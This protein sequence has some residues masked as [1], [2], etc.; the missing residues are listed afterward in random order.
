M[1]TLLFAALLAAACNLPRP[2]RVTTDGGADAMVVA[3]ASPNMVVGHSVVTHILYD[4]SAVMTNEDLSGYKVQAYLPNAGKAS[5]YDI[6]DGSGD[7]NGV[8]TID[9]VPAGATYALVLTPPVSLDNPTP[10][11]TFYFTDHHDLDLGY[12]VL[13][14]PQSKAVANNTPVS[15]TLSNMTTWAHPF[16]EIWVDSL[17]T[18]SEHQVVPLPTT[19]N[20]PAPGAT[21]L[22]GTTFDWRVT[23]MYPAPAQVPRLVEPGDDVMV[24]HVGY[25]SGAG[26]AVHAIV[27]HAEIDGTSMTDGAPLPL[28]GAFTPVSLT[29]HESFS[30]DLSSLEAAINCVGGQESES[31]SF[32]HTSNPAS[33]YGIDTSP[34]LFR[35]QESVTAS[36]HNADTAGVVDATYGDPYPLAWSHAVSAT[37]T[38]PR[39]NG[40]GPAFYEADSSIEIVQSPT[41]S[42]IGA[43]DV[44]VF[45]AAPSSVTIDGHPGSA[46]GTVTFDGSHAVAVSWSPVA[47][48][49]FYEVQVF[50]PIEDGNGDFI[51]NLLATFRTTDASLRVPP[52]LLSPGGVYYFAVGARREGSGYGTGSLRRSE[53]PRAVAVTATETFLLSSLCGN[54]VINAGEACDDG[55]DS[56]GCDADCTVPVCGDGHLNTM[57]GEQCDWGAP[58]PCDRDCTAVVCGDGTWNAHWEECDDGNTTDDGNGCSAQCTL[59]KCGDGTTQ[60]PWEHCDDGNTNSGDGC[61]ERCQVEFG[62]TCS[63]TPSK[64]SLSLQ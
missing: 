61:N 42:T 53:F 30:M 4:G 20:S 16:G 55:G 51:S 23:G 29:S 12:V 48:A 57:A 2:P 13:G 63:G 34:G 54:H 35:V 28:A 41:V 11:P 25:A 52:A 6:I 62:W 58:G 56:A 18:D 3:D 60:G 32:V 5:G 44:D 10:S 19:T 31:Y 33:S 15:L 47:N 64:C 1:R 37:L 8:V 38:C 50:Q 46:G 24:D 14:R 39:F 40:V 59:N 9:N 36:N 49:S 45:V 22:S 26:G 7:A 21:A 17:S 43:A 27:D